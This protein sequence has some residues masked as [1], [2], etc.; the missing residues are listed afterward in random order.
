VKKTATRLTAGPCARWLCID[1]LHAAQA[2]R[3]CLSQAEPSWTDGKRG[4]GREQQ[5]PV[6]LSLCRFSAQSILMVT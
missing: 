2:Q 1:D 4:E 6:L 5:T 3:A